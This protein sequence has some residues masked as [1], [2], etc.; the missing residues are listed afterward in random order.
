[1]LQFIVPSTALQLSHSEVFVVVPFDIPA[2]ELFF[3]PAEW[4]VSSQFTRPPSISSRQPVVQV[5]F[6]A[7]FTFL[8]AF[9]N[10][11]KTSSPQQLSREVGVLGNWNVNREIVLWSETF[12]R[13]NFWSQ[14]R[15]HSISS[16]GG[17][18]P[19]LPTIKFVMIVRL[20][21]SLSLCRPMR[22]TTPHSDTTNDGERLRARRW[23]SSQHKISPL[24]AG[25][26]ARES[27]A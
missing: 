21:S 9:R 4:N 23:Q 18:Q 6:H 17:R 10:I 16:S 2:D 20:S 24:T 11:D 12:R 22:H 14:R 8:D 26:W 3:S 27:K 15:T 5:I 13:F 25:W 7:L 19:I 1:M